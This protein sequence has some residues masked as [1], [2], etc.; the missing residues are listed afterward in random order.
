MINIAPSPLLQKRGMQAL[1]SV[2]IWGGDTLACIVSHMFS[3]TRASSPYNL[4]VVCCQ[5]L[6]AKL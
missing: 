5:L 3:N 6:S 4:P 2:E 1:T